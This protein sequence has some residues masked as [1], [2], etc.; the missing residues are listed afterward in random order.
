MKE[1]TKGGLQN[2]KL[3]HRSPLITETNALYQQS[4][5][6]SDTT[7]NQVNKINS[8]MEIILTIG[9]FI[10]SFLVLSIEK[11]WWSENLTNSSPYR[12][13]HRFRHHRMWNDYKQEIYTINNLVRLIILGCSI[14]FFLV[15]TCIEIVQAF[16]TIIYRVNNTV[17]HNIALRS[18]NTD[19]KS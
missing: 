15:I 17:L 3:F 19:F 11:Y 16:A 8:C 14:A 7:N 12:H 5:I 9:I 6:L 1:P 2:D 4:Y 13:W 10:S 18:G